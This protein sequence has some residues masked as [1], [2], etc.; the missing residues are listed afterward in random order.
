[1]KM[2]KLL[3]WVA[4]SSGVIGTN[5]LSPS[6]RAKQHVEKW[7]VCIRSAERPD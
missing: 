5:I 6:S 4:T 2:S 7:I 3:F 1:M